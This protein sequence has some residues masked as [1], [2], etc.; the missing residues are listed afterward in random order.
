MNESLITFQ[1]WVGGDVTLRQ[2]GGV[3]VANFRVAATPRRFRRSTNEWFDGPT[4]WFTVNAWRGLGEH[5]AGSLRRGD[6]VVVQGR[7]NT[8]TYVNKNEV[9]VTSLEVDALFVGHDLNRGTS[10]FTKASSRGEGPVSDQQ[11]D[12]QASQQTDAWAAAG[13]EQREAPDFAA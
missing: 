13:S 6:P 11:A 10:A 5:C 1:G 7:L 9:E 3:P 12:Q 8:P 2:A 4:Q